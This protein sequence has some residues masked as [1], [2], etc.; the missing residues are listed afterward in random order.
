MSETIEQLREKIERHRLIQDSDNINH[1]TH[2]KLNEG[3]N[4]ISLLCSD[5]ESELSQLKAELEDV[6]NALA[7]LVRLKV[8]KDEHGKDMFYAQAQPEA[9]KTAKKVLY[10]ESE[11][12]KTDKTE[13]K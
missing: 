12:Y 4:E 6:R 3:I 8:H 7:E 10:G 1:Y 9:W 5:L 13:P 2:K 11:V